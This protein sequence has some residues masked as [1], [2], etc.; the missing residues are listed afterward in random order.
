MSN[1][2]RTVPVLGSPT[3]QSVRDN[4][5]IA[6]DEIDAATALANSKLS[7][8]PN[9]GQL[10]ARMTAAWTVVPI[11]LPSTVNPLMDGTAAI[12]TGTTWARADHVHPS[13][14]SRAPVANPTFTGAVNAPT[15]ALSASTLVATTA[16]V[17]NNAP[18]LSS[19]SGGTVDY[20]TIDQAHFGLHNYGGPLTSSANSPPG[21]PTPAKATVL[22]TWAANTGWATQ[23]YMG[24]ESGVP[25]LF[26]RVMPGNATWGAWARVITDQGGAMTAPLLQA[27]DPVVALGTATKQYVDNAVAGATGSAV[28]NKGRNFVHNPLF[29]IWQRSGGPYTTDGYTLDR[30]KVTHSGSDTYSISRLTLTDADRAAIG[31][32]AFQYALRNAFVGN[33]AAGSANFITHGIEDVRRLSGKTVTISFWARASAPLTLR[34]LLYQVMGTGGSPSPGVQVGTHDYAIT[35]AWQ[36]F[37]A[38]T[39]AIPSVSGMTTGT[40]G[41]SNTSLIFYYSSQGAFVQSG[42]IDITGIQIEPGT[43]A[44]PLDKPEP[45]ADFRNCERF[46]QIVGIYLGIFNTG[47]GQAA[48]GSANF[49]TLMRGAP[50]LAVAFNASSNFTVGAP[51]LQSSVGVFMA[52][53]SAASGNTSINLTIACSA[54]Y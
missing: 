53:S 42:T 6:A 43:A 51:G 30:W 16:Y 7:D 5:G 20:N 4:F 48:G 10:Y 32:E 25:N 52:G 2:D 28:N 38:W 19:Q 9:D 47:V 27:A 36:R 22:S 8:A 45:E 3:T 33:A 40:N 18:L 1:I 15:P 49:R 46:Y 35:T 31:D 44:T 34:G 37:T 39:I 17:S 13:D 23:L 26:F 54:E 24:A 12:G 11:P 29:N 41:D 21:V 14:T 50:S